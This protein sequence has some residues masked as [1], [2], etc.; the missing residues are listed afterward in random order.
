MKDIP[1]LSLDRDWR[2]DYFEDIPTI[3]DFIPTTPVPSLRAWRFDQ[4]RDKNQ[5]AWLEK[6]FD[7]PMRDVCVSYRL[8][9][10]AAFYA[11][12]LS[13]NVQDFGEIS[14]PFDQDVT[15]YVM[16]EDN[17]IALRVPYTDAAF[18]DIRLIAIPCN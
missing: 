15:D 12:H 9:I 17:V 1:N 18:N 2:C 13:L 6:R 8:H 16:L 5:I 7:L 4:T 11:A 10:D 14:T 3:H